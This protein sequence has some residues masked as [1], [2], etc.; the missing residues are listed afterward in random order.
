MKKITQKVNPSKRSLKES[1][2]KQNSQPLQVPAEDE[3]DQLEKDK[4]TSEG[5]LAELSSKPRIPSKLHFERKYKESTPR[6]FLTRILMR[7]DIYERFHWY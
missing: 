4:M 3:Y 7:E 1:L 2:E 6:Q 5:G